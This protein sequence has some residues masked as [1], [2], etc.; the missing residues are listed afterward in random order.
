MAVQHKAYSIFDVQF[1]P[2]FIMTPGGKAILK[3]FIDI[4]EGEMTP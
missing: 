3:N 2:E 1:H 4:K